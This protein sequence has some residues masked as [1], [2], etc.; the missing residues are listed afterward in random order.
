MVDI[1]GAARSCGD[2]T[3]RVE[4]EHVVTGGNSDVNRLLG[5][6]SQVVVSALGLTIGRNGG[7]SLGG[8][9]LA[10]LVH[11]LVGVIRLQHGL[12]GCEP[13][14]RP[15][16]PATVATK[17][18]SGARAVNELLLRHD[19]LGVALNDPSRLDRLDG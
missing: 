11:S 3:A 6:T 16:V 19:D 15:E 12:V 5:K 18:T 1:S 14:V 17:V 4:H 7:N 9:V 2:D 8:V 13:I 10:G